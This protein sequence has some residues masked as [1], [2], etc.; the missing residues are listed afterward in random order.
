MTC[1]ICFVA[2]KKSAL[3]IFDHENRLH[4]SHPH[5]EC[6]PIAET[7]YERFAGNVPGY[8]GLQNVCF[9]AFKIEVGSEKH[10]EGFRKQQYIH[11]TI[12]KLPHFMFCGFAGK[13]LL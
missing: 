2:F 7:T 6:T 4:F 13:I 11:G 1:G 9:L 8:G 3:Y 5:P 10:L 12:R